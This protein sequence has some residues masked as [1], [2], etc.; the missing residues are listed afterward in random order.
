[1]RIYIALLLIIVFF[2]CKLLGQQQ[3][4]DSLENRAMDKT[5]ADVNKIVPLLQLGIYYCGTDNDKALKYATESVRL[6]KKE[7]DK[8]YGVYAYASLAVVYEYLDSLAL[9]YSATD[10]CLWYIEKTNDIPAKVSGLNSVVI[11]KELFGEKEAIPD[12]LLHGLELVKEID[13]QKDLF[14]WEL[15]AKLYRS[16]FSYYQSIDLKVAKKYLDKAKDADL[17]INI[18]MLIIRTWNNYCDYYQKAYEQFPDGEQY[19]DSA[20]YVLNKAENIYDKHQSTILLLD[21]LPVVYNK[22]QIYQM[23][24]KTDSA[25]YYA[26]RA[27]LMAESLS[28]YNYLSRGFN[29]LS[30]IYLTEGVLDGAEKY[31][32]KAIA[33]VQKDE[34]TELEE[35][36]QSD[37]CNVYQKKGDYKKAFEH[38]LSALECRKKN[39]EQTYLRDAQIMN[40]KFQVQENKYN[41]RKAQK[42]NEIYLLYLTT[43]LIIIIVLILLLVL[44]RLKWKNA[45]QSAVI[46]Q[47][48]SELQ[49]REAE[50]VL[51]EKQTVELQLEVEKNR[52]LL[53][54]YEM[55][56]LQKELIAG[57]LQLD[58]KSSIIERIKSDIESKGL[59]FDKAN[60]ERIIK[61]EKKNNDKFEEFSTYIKKIHPDFYTILQENAKQKLTPLDLKYCVFIFMNLTTKDIASLLYIEPKT[62]RM[63]KYRLKLKLGLGK[64][65]DLSEFIRNAI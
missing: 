64:D 13:P 37:I 54:A 14:R 21:Y 59:V 34:N 28:D 51:S 60:I 15:E 62:V 39:N 46:S 18:P 56:K 8:K 16:M 55:N 25:I 7:N 4:L 19:L 48:N 42:Q 44:F 20:I 32:L 22:A 26:N 43:G 53:K 47:K 40:A 50:K 36:F 65:D 61:D 27:V 2:P 58:Y 5:L 24:Q 9:C 1:M 38:S 35:K 57:N 17:K 6:A 11:I 41:L 33:T 63:T 52:A 23:K 45:R 29:L 3:L 31:G 10:T 49:K 12:L 30:N